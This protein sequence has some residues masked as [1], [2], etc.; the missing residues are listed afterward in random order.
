MPRASSHTAWNMGSPTSAPAGSASNKT[1]KEK[2]HDLQPFYNYETGCATYL[3]GGATLGTCAVVDPL[4]R[5]EREYIQFA[6]SM[7]MG[8]TQVIET[9][10]HAD[11]RSGGPRLCRELEEV[12][13]GRHR[14]A[15]VS[16]SYSALDDGRELELGSTRIRVLHTPGHTPE[17]ICLVVT[18]SA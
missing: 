17:S 15:P 4:E 5:F 14:L 3:F 12:S 9:H 1:P 16:L 7:G 11:H 10:V 2:Q 8:V 18:E 13:Y 6:N